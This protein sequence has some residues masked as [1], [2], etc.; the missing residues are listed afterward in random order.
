M[1]NRNKQYGIRSWCQLVKQYDTDG[2]RNVRIKRLESVL[3]TIFHRNYRRG[4][5]QWIQD[6]EDAFTELVLLGKDLE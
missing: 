1:E 6:H 2:N 3:N 5:V 4:L